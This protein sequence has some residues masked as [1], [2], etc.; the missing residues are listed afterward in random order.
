MN[1]PGYYYSLC[2][3]NENIWLK[4]MHPAVIWYYNFYIEYSI[5]IKVISFIAW[6]PKS[7]ID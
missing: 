5:N 3:I 1:Q 6:I 4:L 7:G 2:L